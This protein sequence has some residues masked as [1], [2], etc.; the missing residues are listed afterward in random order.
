[1]ILCK[2]TALRARPPEFPIIL[3]GGNF[4]SRGLNSAPGSPA[5]L[6]LPSVTD[7]PGPGAYTWPSSPMPRLLAATL[8]LLHSEKRNPR[9]VPLVSTS[10]PPPPPS[11]GRQGPSPWPS[12]HGPS[13]PSSRPTRRCQSAPASPAAR[14]SVPS[15]PFSIASQRGV[16]PPHRGR[17]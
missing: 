2:T 3:D 7:L 12:P 17:L 1:M 9:S 10:L 6:L 15:V 14:L 4:C 13:P 5:S 16:R 11:P 8:K